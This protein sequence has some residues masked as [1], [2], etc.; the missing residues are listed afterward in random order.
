[1]STNAEPVACPNCH[2]SDQTEVAIRLTGSDEDGV[3]DSVYCKLCQYQS[4][5]PEST[6]R[7]YESRD[8]DGEVVPIEDVPA[9]ARA[10]MTED[11]W[12]DD[13]ID[14]NVQSWVDPEWLVWLNSDDYKS[15]QAGFGPIF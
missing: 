1:M 11:G 2:V 15:R 9:R 10:L 13:D 5:T 14:E 7:Y 12:S 6:D 8:F 4:L 3:S